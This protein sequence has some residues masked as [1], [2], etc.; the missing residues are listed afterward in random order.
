MRMR[1]RSWD[2]AVGAEEVI[3][4]C[5]TI[6][7]A[8]VTSTRAATNNW[9]RNGVWSGRAWARSSARNGHHDKD[10]NNYEHKGKNKSKNSFHL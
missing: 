5:H 8:S 2:V 10:D 1:M 3:F 6:G 9:V 4:G 7:A